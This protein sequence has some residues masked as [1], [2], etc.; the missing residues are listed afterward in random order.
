MEV[1][2]NWTS[3]LKI[4]SA[5]SRWLKANCIYTRIAQSFFQNS[6]TTVATSRFGVCRVL[7]LCFPNTNSLKV[8]L[9]KFFPSF[10]SSGNPSEPLFQGFC[11]R[12]FK[13]PEIFALTFEA[14]VSKTKVS[15]QLP[16]SVT[17]LSFMPIQVPDYAMSMKPLSLT[18]QGQGHGQVLS[19]QC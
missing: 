1:A 11:V 2:A 9:L 19:W 18:Q 6:R 8:C 15:F 12:G 16:V 13:F 7:S 17:L 4:C 5:K 14:A 3:L 10:Y